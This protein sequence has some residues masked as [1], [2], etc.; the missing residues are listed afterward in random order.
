MAQ[1]ME[2][3]NVVKKWIHEAQENLHCSLVGDA[4]PVGRPK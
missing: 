2:D 1:I 3:H 4:G